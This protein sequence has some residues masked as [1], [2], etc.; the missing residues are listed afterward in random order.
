MSR[1]E[2]IAQNSDK[3]AAYKDAGLAPKE[4][5][6]AFRA[7]GGVHNGLRNGFPALSATGLPLA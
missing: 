2:K 3:L 5:L 6:A 4:A 7:G 1:S